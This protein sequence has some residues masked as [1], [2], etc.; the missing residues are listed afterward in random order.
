M[1]SIARFGQQVNTFS[2]VLP[3]LYPSGI[4]CF[5]KPRQRRELAI[6]GKLC[7]SPPKENARGGTP[8]GG[9]WVRIL[10]A[11]LLTQG[12]EYGTIMLSNSGGAW[13]CP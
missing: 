5:Q 9:K 3:Y 12:A 8:P 10:P 11:V 1:Y 7:C 6:L 13:R 4:R 2:N